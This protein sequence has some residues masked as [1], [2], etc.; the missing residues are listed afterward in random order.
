M[1]I[2]DVHCDVIKRIIFT[3]HRQIF[4]QFLT[5]RVLKDPRQ[6]RFFKSN[7]VYDLFTLDPNSR[8]GSTETSAI[9]AGTG[10]EV[11]LKKRKKEQTTSK[12]A[13]QVRE[14]R[15][16]KQTNAQQ[17][18]SSLVVASPSEDMSLLDTDTQHDLKLTEQQVI[19]SHNSTV[20][21][22]PNSLVECCNQEDSAVRNA[23]IDS[24]VPSSSDVGQLKED[25]KLNKDLSPDQAP[26][27]KSPV[28]AEL[29]NLDLF[30]IQRDDSVVKSKL[31]KRKKHKKKRRERAV[32]DG[33]EVEGIDRSCVFEPGSGDEES[34]R[35]QDDFVLKKLFKKTGM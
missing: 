26:A 11:S 5:N 18:P 23:Q 9:F 16:K 22:P 12:E 15:K 6:R 7:D 20:A 35:K 14:K 21:S 3:F 17:A 28:K 24:G 29:P 2:F 10:S 1:I 30:D 13:T 19:E 25:T 31:K 27:E 4:K 32:V 33:M 34:G 8:D